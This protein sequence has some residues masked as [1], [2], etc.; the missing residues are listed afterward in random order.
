MTKPL[1]NMKKPRVHIKFAG[2]QPRTLRAYRLAID[3]FLHFAGKDAVAT[4]KPK[5]LDRLLAEFIN[6][7]FQ[8]GDPLTYSGHLL[9]ALKRFHPELRLQ[10][11]I[12]TQ[13][14]RNWTRAHVPKRAVPASWELV[15]AMIALALEANEQ[16]LALLLGIGFHAMLRT[17]EMMQLTVN[18]ILIH[19]SKQAFSVVIPTAKTSQGNPQVLQIHDETLWRMAEKV[20]RSLQPKALLWKTGPHAFRKRFQQLLARLGFPAQS[21]LPYSLRRGGATWYY[22]TTLNLD[23]TMTRG[24][25]ACQKTCRIYVDTGTLQLAHLSWTPKQA[26][27]VRQWRLKGANLRLRQRKTNLAYD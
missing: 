19:S 21:Y 8:E 24:R 7:S 16:P 23:A 12:A 2:L 25:W 5:H 15:E 6:R 22:Q 1:A 11:P 18:H 17:S 3:N 20:G 27:R 13:Y 9:S 10:L 26:K 14:L 4:L